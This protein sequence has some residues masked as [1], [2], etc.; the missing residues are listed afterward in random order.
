MRTLTAQHSLN[1]PEN[2]PAYPYL[3]ELLK[4]D[5]RETLNVLSLAFMEQ[6]F[7]TELG[8][9]QRQR[10]IN[11]LLEIVTDREDNQFGILCNF[12]SQQITTQILPDAATFLTK[13]I[14]YI[15]SEETHSLTSRHHIEKEQTFMNLMEAN[16]LNNRFTFEELLEIAMRTKCYVVA[17]HILEKLKRYEKMVE[18]YVLSGDKHE[19]F[20]YIMVY[21]NSDE[22]KI[23]SQIL[24]HFHSL[25]GMDCEKT[26]KLI[27]EFYPI[28]IPQFLANVENNP[29]LCYLFL[30]ELINNNVA[31][32]DCEYDGFLTLLSQYNPENVLEFLQNAN[33][34]YD[35]TRALKLCEEKS[36]TSSITYLY[37]KIGD[38][39]KA[40][41]LSMDL[42]K[43]APEAQA[44][45]QA[46]RLCS[47]CARIS[48]NVS[49][50]E[51][52]NFWFELIETVLSRNYLNSI[53]KQVLHLS[54]SY[55]DLTK[56]VQLIMRNE[57]QTNNFGDIKH[58][59]VDM[60]NN[61]EYES[62][63]L[64]T[65]QNIFGR[66]LHKMLLREKQL[67]EAGIYGKSLKC[68][69][70]KRKLSDVIMS[71]EEDQIIVLSKCGHSIHNSCYQKS[72]KLVDEGDESCDKN[73]NSIKCQCGI[74]ISESD[75]IY[76]NKTNFNLIVI[77]N[78]EETLELKLKS[79]TRLGFD[80]KL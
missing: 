41:S 53:V 9:S 21:K 74:V 18:C 31:L 27:T 1:S 71:S 8:L 44:E 10:I 66:D 62:M 24:K 30:N 63:V 16:A 47:L 56:L 75:S 26:T 38:F 78:V 35:T 4:F 77:S 65:T 7:N 37:E 22:R 46:L 15:T 52:E 64:K 43:E 42:L 11:I 48:K 70:C 40:F 5:T 33:H 51:R 19:L 45:N 25:L 80:C 58:I 57:D 54:S 79:P 20:R 17:Q 68:F 34:S 39:K 73:L 14:N 6:E 13:I 3:R 67:A 76:L 29:K 49:D 61:F 72:E 28:C 50:S 69:L 59:L 36:L 2:E 60:L 32:D 23:F 12:I 55:V